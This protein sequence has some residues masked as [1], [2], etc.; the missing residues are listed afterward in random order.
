MGI[1]GEGIE[2]N[3]RNDIKDVARFLNEKHGQNYLIFNLT[4]ESYDY[5][6]FNGQVNEEFDFPDHHPPC[7]GKYLA[8]VKAIDRWITMSPSHVAVVHCLAGRFKYFTVL[9]SQT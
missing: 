5:K 9:I 4:G 2:K 3:W 8:A 1:P 6:K 7:M